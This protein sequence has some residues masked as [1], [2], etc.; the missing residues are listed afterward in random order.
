MRM[1]QVFL[2]VNVSFFALKKLSH[3]LQPLLMNEALSSQ[4]KGTTKNVLL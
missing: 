1:E 3:V 4:I 2:I